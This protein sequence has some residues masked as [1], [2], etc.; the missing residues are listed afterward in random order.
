MQ[1]HLSLQQKWILRGLG[2]LSL[3]GFVGLP[4]QA[5]TPDEA[6]HL[7]RRVAFGP[8]VA[9]VQALLPLTR[10]QAVEKLIN[11]TRSQSVS[12]LPSLPVLEKKRQ[13]QNE[14]QTQKNQRER[15]AQSQQLKAW[16]LQ[17]MLVTPSPL[18]ETMTLF[19]HNH[20]TSSLKKVKSPTL[21]AKQNQLLRRYALGSFADLLQAISCDPAMLRYLDGAV[22]RK[23]KPNENFARELLELFTLGE[24]HYQEA[25]IK[26]AA[27][28]FSGWSL[29]PNGQAVFKTKQH[30]QGNK[31]FMGQ[32][33]PWRGEDIIRI[34][35]A[36]PRT[37]EY[38]AFQLWKSLISPNPNP[39]L[40]KRW[41]AEFARNQYQIK[42]LLKTILTSDAFWAERGS[43]IKSPIELTV[44]SFRSL[45]LP[46]D[47]E[48]L[49][50]TSRQLGQ[51][52]FN[53]PNVKG[54]PGG[55]N[56]IDSRTLV[57]RQQ[58]LTRLVE[59][60][61]T[62]NPVLNLSLLPL[63]PSPASDLSELLLDQRY[64]LK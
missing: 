63:A 56:W 32:T 31:T 30:D 57:A 40:V 61:P 51:D 62:L 17:E 52:L 28:A 9:T 59:M 27:R 7:L 48:G 54:W 22:N 29:D 45:G 53:P 6:G 19:W 34:I 24:G 43:L 12:A 37:G 47:A 3:L 11:E 39:T 5:L 33:G 50:L 38:L 41:G 58:F 25:D 60:R 2:C 1:I 49:V 20:F 46:P 36:Q 21:M 23:A 35:L 10:T 15:N 18:T 16:W 14:A 64:Q 44:G 13:R 26:A 8:Q 4:A 42:P 55:P